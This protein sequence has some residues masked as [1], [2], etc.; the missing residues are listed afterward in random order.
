MLAAP[1]PGLSL[2]DAGL[3]SRRRAENTYKLFEG[4]LDMLDV[5]F[6]I[7]LFSVLTSARLHHLAF[8]RLARIRSSKLPSPTLTPYML[9]RLTGFA[10]AGAS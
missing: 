7:T 6:W 1:V 4:D 9:P 10:A 3:D 5:C 8:S 2:A